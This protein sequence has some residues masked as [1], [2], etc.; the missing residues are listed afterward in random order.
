M[1]P[2]TD[3]LEEDYKNSIGFLQKYAQSLGAEYICSKLEKFTTIS[4]EGD[5]IHETLE[6]KIYKFKD[7][8]FWLEHHFL[9][10]CPFIVFFVWGFC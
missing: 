10:D 1:W 4:G 6:M 9:P 2:Y 7:E 3:H 8:Y 5:P